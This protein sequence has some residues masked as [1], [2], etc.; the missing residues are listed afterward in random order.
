MARCNELGYIIIETAT[1]E[2]PVKCD[3]IGTNNDFAVGK[4]VLQ[5][6]NVTNRNRRYYED[7]ELF[8]Q[9]SSPRTVELVQTGN[10]RAENGH[11]LE[12]DIARQQTIDPNKTCA[13]FLSM[14]TEGNFV[15]GTFRG[16]N[17]EKGRE[18]DADLKDGFKPSWSLRALGKIFDDPRKG[19]VVRGIKLITYDRV[20]YPSHKTAYTEGLVSESTG[21]RIIVPN[22]D[23]GMIIPITNKQVLDYIKTESAN[24][25]ICTEALEYDYNDIAVISNGSQVQLTNYKDGD[26]LVINL[27][28]YIQ[29][30]IMNDCL[31]HL[32]F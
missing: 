18:F 5:E 16:T 11:P 21:N 19:A 32:P 12:K 25:R 26:S 6:A 20:I 1:V 7:A 8:P 4:G 9:I 24:M 17:N 13:I 3:I 14:W 31:K 10:M 30:E 2:A 23:P 29:D 27:E 15:K 28:S 22:E